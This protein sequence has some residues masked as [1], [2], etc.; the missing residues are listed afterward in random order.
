MSNPAW[1][2]RYEHLHGSQ[3]KTYGI[4]NSITKRF[5]YDIREPSPALA[6]KKLREINPSGWR[7]ARYEARAIPK[8][9]KNPPN[10]IWKARYCNEQN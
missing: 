5:V 10:E 1:K 6:N 8:G 7:C 4:W 3:G 9:W 2:R